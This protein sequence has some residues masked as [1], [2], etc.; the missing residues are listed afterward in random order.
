MIFRRFFLPFALV[1]VLAA[2]GACTQIEPVGEAPKPQAASPAA[3]AHAAAPQTATP[4]SKT[5][6]PAAAAT[7]TSVPP[8]E[9]LSEGML[10]E[11]LLGEIAAQRGDPE[12]AASY[13]FV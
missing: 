3:P 9:S 6:A 2:A 10:Y 12:L 7:A 5:A 13:N 4:H 8:A 1:A 11:F